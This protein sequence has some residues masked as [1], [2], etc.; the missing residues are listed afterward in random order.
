[1]IYNVYVY[2]C[3]SFKEIYRQIIYLDGYTIN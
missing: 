2:V 1:M 3:A